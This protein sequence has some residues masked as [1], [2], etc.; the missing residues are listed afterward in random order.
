MCGDSKLPSGIKT[1]EETG[2]AIK[3]TKLEATHT[4]KAFLM[5]RLIPWHQGGREGDS[6]DSI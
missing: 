5:R 2:C 1:G 3:L 4:S 6:L